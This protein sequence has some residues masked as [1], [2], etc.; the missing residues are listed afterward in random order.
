MKILILS[1]KL[2]YPPKDGGSIATLNMLTGLRDAGNQLTC[3]SLNTSK[4][5]YP[6][7]D[8]PSEIGETIRFMGVACDTSIKPLR[9]LLNL[10]FT[11]QP[12]IAERFKTQAYKKALSELLRQE[13]FDV[14]QLEGPYVGHYADLIR[15]TSK[16]TLSLRTHNV[17]HLIWKKKALHETSFLKRWYLK[18]MASRLERFEMKVVHQTDCLVSISPTDETYFKNRGYT[19]PILTIPTGL[20]IDAYPLTSIPDE[21]TLF[22]IGALDWLPNQE[23]LEW[24]IDKVFEQI[25]DKVPGLSFHVAG[26]NAPKQFESKLR[27]PKIVYHGEVEDACRFMQKYRVMV[28]PLLT[29]SGIRIKIL[30]GMAL[31]RPVVTTQTGIEGIPVENIEGVKVSDD[32]YIFANHVVDLLNFKED[33]S[34]MLSHSRELIIE[35]FDTFRLS[36]RLSQFF[37][38]Q[39]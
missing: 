1:N 24:F 16:S 38:T 4:H 28:V 2:P 34:Q 12:Y 11:K 18:N 23:G 25:T 7:E 8:I 26:R 20:S 37:K 10:L 17:E 14:I 22:F 21:P 36:T 32:P 29:G 31:G 15:K 39:V 3:L 9:M 6:I 19:R 5:P 13:S 27:H 30:E 35:N 33:T